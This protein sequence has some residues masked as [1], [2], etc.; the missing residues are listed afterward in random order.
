MSRR[1]LTTRGASPRKE[2]RRIEV[3]ARLTLA[4]GVVRGHDSDSPGS[5]AG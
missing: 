5:F 4:A 2:A 1:L 3:E